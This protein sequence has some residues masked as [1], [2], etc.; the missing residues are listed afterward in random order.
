MRDGK[1]VRNPIRQPKMESSQLS[2]TCDAATD[3]WWWR[4][5]GELHLRDRQSEK[6]PQKL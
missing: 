1:S 3:G 2:Y 4:S 6:V 5:E